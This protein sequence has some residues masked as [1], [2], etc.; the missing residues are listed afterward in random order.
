IAVN[1]GL[2]GDAFLERE[3]FGYEKGA[4][5]GAAAAKRGK[6][7]LAQGG[8]IFLDKIDQLG[9][10]CQIGL[11]RVMQAGVIYRVGG[12]QAVPVDIR[13]IAATGQEL[14]SHITQGNFKQDLADWIGQVTLHIPPLKQRPKDLR[15]I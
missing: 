12:G 7:E 15:A 13:I 1:C 6:I 11:A 3:L 9:T 10:A 14:I 4:F 5:E 2:G 8:T